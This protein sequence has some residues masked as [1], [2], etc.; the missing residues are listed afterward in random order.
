[1]ASLK[2]LRVDTTKVPIR[3]WNYLTSI[4]LAIYILLYSKEEH[5]I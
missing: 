4:D 5:V 2:I 1:M 3:Y